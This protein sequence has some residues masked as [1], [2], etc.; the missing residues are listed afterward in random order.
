[1]KRKIAF[2][3]LFGLILVSVI[4]Y[5]RFRRQV[6]GDF[7]TGWLV[8]RYVQLTMDL[9]SFAVDSQALK[10]IGGPTFLPPSLP[11]RRGA[12]PEMIRGMPHRQT[13]QKTDL[14]FQNTVE[15]TVFSG[16]QFSQAPVPVAKDSLWEF[17]GARAFIIDDCTSETCREET[18]RAKGEFFHRHRLDGSFH[19]LLSPTDAAIAVE[20]G[21]A[22][23]FPI[24]GSLGGRVPEG[25][26]LV[27]APR[28]KTEVGV[29]EAIL[30]SAY[31]FATK[32]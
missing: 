13:T 28:D 9:D 19:V 5:L 18:A 27:Y 12:R 3:V 29:L 32:R 8:S 20:K 15:G 25:I 14:A 21:W 24:A 31:R 30:L 16:R 26:I 23:R 7:L 6:E 11:Q 10:T 17:T 22:E 2:G 1:M 4:D